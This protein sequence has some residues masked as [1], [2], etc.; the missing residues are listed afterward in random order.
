[1]LA[2]TEFGEQP[3]A[4]FEQGH[5]LFV[6]RHTFYRG[7]GIDVD[8]REARRQEA[9]RKRAGKGFVEVERHVDRKRVVRSAAR[10]Q[11][12][13]DDGADGRNLARE[14]EIQLATRLRVVLPAEVYLLV[15]EHG[16]QDGQFVDVLL[17]AR[18]QQVGERDVVVNAADVEV[19]RRARVFLEV[20]GFDVAD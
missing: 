1:A 4:L 10:L 16:A 13:G 5:G 6:E 14:R 12:H 2:L 19:F 11:F 8:H 15:A 18:E 9:G 7:V 17:H 20:E 3:P